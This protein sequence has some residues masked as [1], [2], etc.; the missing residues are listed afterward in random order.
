MKFYNYCKSVFWS[1]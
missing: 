1:N